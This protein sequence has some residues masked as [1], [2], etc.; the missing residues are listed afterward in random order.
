MA[1]FE[2]IIPD[3]RKGKKFR[4]AFWKADKHIYLE[5]DVPNWGDVLTDQDGLS[6]IFFAF[7]THWIIDEDDDWE[8]IPEPIRVADYLVEIT[9]PT[10]LYHLPFT[11]W[12]KQTHPIGQQPEGS[13]MVPGSERSQ[14]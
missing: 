5:R 2:D 6:A 8:I 3:I 10:P 14:D 12:L 7:E 13:V 11:H 9:D 4:R 1:K